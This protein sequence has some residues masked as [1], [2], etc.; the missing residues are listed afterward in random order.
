MT[1]AATAPDSRRDSETR[2]LEGHEEPPSRLAANWGLT[3]ELA[4]TSFKLKYA[5][6]FLGYVWTLVKP[7]ILFGTMYVVFALFL[8]RGRTA[9][10]ENFPVE[11]LLGIVAWSF[12]AEA[13]TGALYAIVGNGEMIRKARFPRW[14]LVLASSVSAGMTLSINV[15]LLIVVGLLLHWYDTGVQ[16]LLVPALLLELYVF[17][18]GLGFLLAALFVTFRDLGHIWEIA[19]QL[20]FYASAIVFPLSL[21]PGSFRIL[22]ALNPLAQIIEDMRHVLVSSA[23]PSSIA[24][25]GWRLAVPL[26]VVSASALVGALLFSRLSRGFGERL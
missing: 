22:V 11:L 23:A 21:I 9:A 4:V 25:L 17:A 7:L 19:L 18:L 8:L 12:F 24:V 3:K 2:L 26:A 20:L 5:G 16:A 14:T 6:S 13:T 15:A 10:Q 1:Q